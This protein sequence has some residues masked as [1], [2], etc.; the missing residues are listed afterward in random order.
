MSTESAVPVISAIDLFCGVG[1]L[2]HGLIRGGINVRAGYDIDPECK[3]SYEANNPAKFVECDVADLSADMIRRDIGKSSLTLLAG[4]APCQPFSTYSRSGRSK[5][6]E[7]DWQLVS[8]FGQLVEEI[9][10]DLVTMENVSQ[11]ADHKVFEEFLSCLSSYKVS[12]SVVE[13]SALGVP[14]SR[15]RLVLLASQLGASHLN[16]PAKAGTAGTVRDAIYDLP[17]VNAG[18]QHADDQLHKASALSPLNLKRIQASVPGGTWRDWDPDLR[19]SCHHKPTGAT[20]PSVYGRMEWDK[21]APTITTQCFGYGNGRFGHPE[22]DRAITLREAAM[23]QTFPRDYEFG[24]PGGRLPFNKIGR[25]IGNAVPVRMGEVI[26]Q[27]LH[28][29]ASFYR[30]ARKD[31]LTDCLSIAGTEARRRHPEGAWETMT[32]RTEG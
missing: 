6:S 1:G 19:A 32:V 11:L 3:Y 24:P 17:R 7:L 5:Q 15:R 13:C 8:K 26:G 18:E 16:M 21:E 10:P 30:P 22:Q 31:L 29:H 23:L 9:K 20:Y 27:V 28:R 25:W 2:T 4:C 12:W 14:Q